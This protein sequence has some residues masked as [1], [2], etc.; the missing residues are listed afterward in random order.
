LRVVPA[1]LLRMYIYFSRPMS[2]RGIARHIRL[3]DDGGQP[4]ERAFLEMEDGLWDPEGRRLTLFLHPGRIKRGLAMHGA[5]GLPLRAGRR[6]R[7][8]VDQKA[9]DA[10]GMPLAEV[11][12]KQF[13]VAAEDRRPPAVLRWR[14]DTPTAGERRPAMWCCISG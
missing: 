8:V 10:D 1:N 4:V 9:E 14:L 3:L 5:L 11:Y 13:G 7:L 12:S 2:R 6:Y